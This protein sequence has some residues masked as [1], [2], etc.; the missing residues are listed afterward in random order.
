MER[1]SELIK[2]GNALVA[3]TDPA[4]K[5]EG[6]KGNSL[7]KMGNE[8]AQ[9]EDTRLVKTMNH[10]ATKGLRFVLFLALPASIFLL[11]TFVKEGTAK[12]VMRLDGFLKIIIKWDGYTLDVNWNVVSGSEPWPWRWL[13]GLRF[14]GIWP[15]DEV[16]KY[17]FRWT[18]FELVSGELMVKFYEKILDYILLRPDVYATEIKGAET[19]A[20]ATSADPAT[21]IE[22]KVSERIAIGLKFL[23]TMR[24]ENPFKVLFKGPS[25]WFENAIARFDTAARTWV[26][27]HR[28]DEILELKSS[29]EDLWN[30]FKGIP[31]LDTT[32]PEWGIVVEDNGIEIKDVDIP[33]EYQEAAALEAKN[34]LISSGFKAETADRLVA[35]VQGLSGKD[36]KE[37]Q[38]QFNEDPEE[39][40][41][42]HDKLTDLIRRRLGLGAGQQEILA[43]VPG[44][45]A[46]MANIFHGGFSGGG[47]SSGAVKNSNANSGG[48]KKGKLPAPPAV[49]DD[50]DELTMEA[51]PG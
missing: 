21:G 40:L 13:G 48:K 14:V 45:L 39:F 16:Y 47:G 5:D 44:F 31:L 24:P 11:F 3:K 36:V 9:K 41:N 49:D 37:I 2:E 50:D 17:N 12:A 30:S 19:K 26:S 23:L 22:A 51:E 35:M 7:I 8:L 33:D 1:G 29:P 10:K 38:D 34:R 27:T 6:E 28:L 43:S 32:F 18:G 25:N 20:V 42:K 46:A 4:K 15:F